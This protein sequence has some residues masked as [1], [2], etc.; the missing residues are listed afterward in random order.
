MAMGIRTP[1]IVVPLVAD[2]WDDDR[3]RAVLLHEL[4]HI[5]RHDCFAQ[6]LASLACAVYSAASWVWLSGAPAAPRT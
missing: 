3:R 5:A 4:S 6:V 2:T 1:V